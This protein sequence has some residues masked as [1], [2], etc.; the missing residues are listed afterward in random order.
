VKTS[1]QLAVGAW[2]VQPGD[3]WGMDHEEW[4]WL[5]EIKKPRDRQNDYAGNLTQSDVEE[6]YELLH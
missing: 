3:F 5:Y 6:L 1:Y 4:W 2:G